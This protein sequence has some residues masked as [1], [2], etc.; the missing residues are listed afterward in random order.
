MGKRSLKKK[1]PSNAVPATKTQA[2]TR[3]PA[4]WN[5]FLLQGM[6]IAVASFWIFWPALHGDWLWDDDFDIVHNT[7]MQGPA[8]LWKIWFE[9]GSQIDYYPVKASVQWIQ[10][11]L[12]GL[13]SF[14]Y[15][16]TNLLLHILSGLLLWRLLAKFGLR[17]AWLGGLLFVIHP[18][19]V[20]SVAWIAELKNT[21]S[22]PP[23]LLAMCAFI[24]YDEYKRLRDYLLAVGLFLVA[25]LCKP[26]MVLF[27]V[28]ILLHAWWKRNSIQWSDFKASAPF[29]AISLALG[30]LTLF[31]GTW[32]YQKNHS[33]PPA[34]VLLGGPLSR[35]ACSGL[36]IAFYFSKCV[37]PVGLLTN[38]P[39]WV[40]DP[41]SPIQFLPWLVFAILFGWFWIN[42]N[43][44]GRHALFGFG[45]FFLN[46]LPF[47]GL[48]S[49]FY[50]NFTWV[51]DHF[52]YIPL[53]GLIG[54]AVAGLENI[55]LRL[56]AQMR[57][58]GIGLTIF[59]MALLAWESRGYAGLYINQKNL[60]TYTLERNPQAW[61]AHCAL[62]FALAKAGEPA[63]AIDQFNQ[64][65]RIN[66]GYVIA[67][68]GLGTALQQNHQ[69]PE[70]IDQFN[71]AL[72]LGPDYAY[73][74]N[75]LGLALMQ[76]GQ[77]DEAIEQYRL[78]LKLDP[79]YVESFYNLGN[80]LSQANRLSEA[81]KQYQSALAIDPN[82][83]AAR[84]NLG[85][86][87][88]RQGHL[89]E[90]VQQMKEI[91]RIDPA[92]AEAHNNLGGMLGQQNHLAEAIEQ[93]EQAVRINPAYVQAH[94]NLGYAL[95]QS[96][97]T[98]EAIEQY[99]LSLKL[100]PDDPSVQNQ[101]ARL[102]GQ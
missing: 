96:G 87:L 80:A 41:P 12:W 101:L 54:L 83:T 57:S 39:K 89:D 32:W 10:W 40:V 74:R 93:F 98:A 77:T 23:F 17:L 86:L 16:L 66:P 81:I 92:N 99:K 85:N 45:F 36:T 88:A 15:H 1:R 14:G 34:N 29:F 70:A 75:N 65:I 64:S 8:G 18:V 20:E 42:R 76:A 62:G 100:N 72:K 78:A 67:H 59:L 95:A 22:L 91:I 3:A 84:I 56:P 28:I 97:R 61:F 82:Y 46:L 21:L 26:T 51:M 71:L 31:V 47:S 38:Y 102:H 68:F 13:D 79:G 58:F 69:L 2:R 52:L 53:I 35:L 37:L 55:D 63:E 27:P 30:M 60:W 48:T 43:G 44:W 9:P 4:K 73:A 19:Q 24:D 5:L 7:A 6:I 50:M 11:N 33:Q 49:T 25:M 94:N 90:A